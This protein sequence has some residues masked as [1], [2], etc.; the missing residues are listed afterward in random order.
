MPCVQ[1]I[2]D[3]VIVVSL[4]VSCN[5][6]NQKNNYIRNLINKKLDYNQILVDYNH[7]YKI[8]KLRCG[9]NVPN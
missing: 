7:S 6:V 1:H 9:D 5:L 8:A 3:H 2:Q 4:L